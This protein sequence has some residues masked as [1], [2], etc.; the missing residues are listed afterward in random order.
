[1][2]YA[3]K[4]QRNSGCK[5]PIRSLEAP[6]VNGFWSLSVY[7]E[8]HFFIAMR[9]IVSPAARKTKTSSRQST[10]PFTIY[11]QADAPTDPAQRANWL[12]RLKVTSRS[13]SEPAGQ[14]P[15]LLTARGRLWRFSE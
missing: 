2:V 5:H 9:S 10:A 8:H 4:N 1:V 6:P 14:N 3:T 7:N 11:V 13:M 12:P 15:R